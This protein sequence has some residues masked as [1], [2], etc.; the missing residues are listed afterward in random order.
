ME[1]RYGTNSV[2]DKTATDVEQ[3]HHKTILK[4]CDVS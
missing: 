3:P 4:D 1:K 2:N